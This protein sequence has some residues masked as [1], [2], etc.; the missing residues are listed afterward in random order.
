MGVQ[1]R[2]TSRHSAP[3]VSTRCG[4]GIMD[5]DSSMIQSSRAQGGRETLVLEMHLYGE[6]ITLYESIY[7]GS[8]PV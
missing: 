2:R 4:P 5:C 1:F 3:Q 6:K 8:E 7:A